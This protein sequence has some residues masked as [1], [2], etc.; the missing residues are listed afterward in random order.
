MSR[1]DVADLLAHLAGV[2]EDAA[3]GEY[4]AGAMDAWRDPAL[5]RAREDVDG[6]TL[7]A[8]RPTA[9]GASVHVHAPRRPVGRARCGGATPPWSTAPPWMVSAPVGDLAVHLADLRE[10]LGLPPDETAPSPAS[11]FGAYRDWLHHRLVVTGLPALRLTDGRREWL[12]GEGEP[13]RVRHCL[14]PMSC[15]A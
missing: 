14:P 7:R 9:R 1:L 11:G 2:A 15:S 10:A 3:R 12:V 4:F 6:G 5:A 13:G 8:A